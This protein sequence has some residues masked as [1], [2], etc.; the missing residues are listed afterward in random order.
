MTLV[1]NATALL[2]LFLLAACASTKIS[3]QDVYDGPQLPR[4]KHII[5]YDFTADPAKIPADSELAAH[6][7]QALTPEQIKESETLGAAVA[8]QLVAK[9]SEAGLPA[10]RAAAVPTPELNDIEIKGYFVTVEEGS[11]AKRV[12]VGF[13]SG[14]AELTTMVAGY[15]VT[16]NGLER[17]G[18]ADIKSE[19]GKIPG[20][21]LPAA[22]LAATANPIGLVVGGTVKAVQ[23]VDGSA[24]VE[25]SAERTADEIATQL[26]KAAKKQGW[27]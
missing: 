14:D 2:A 5:V 24:T 27:I 26:E 23:E 6:A 25:G 12:L 17:L 20:L 8:K 9:L 19:G 22:V 21:V 1:R 18:G 11:A 4:P 13:G 3:D 16:P 7:G 15:R 10:V